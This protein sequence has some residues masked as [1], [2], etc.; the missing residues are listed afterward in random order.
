M[1]FLSWQI[2]LGALVLLPLFLLPARWVGR[3]LQAITREA[4]Q[5]N[6]EHGHDDDRA[7]QRLRRAAGQA[8]RP[9][10]DEESA[11]FA[12]KAGQVRDIGIKQAMYGRVFFT[13]LTLVASLATALVYGVGGVLVIDGDDRR[14]ARWSR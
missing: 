13:G 9:A 10:C 12:D 8:V 14:S 2:T 5:L 3:K 6:A 1:L 11:A 4:M 7:V